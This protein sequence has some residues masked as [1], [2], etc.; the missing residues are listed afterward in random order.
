M[1][2][3]FLADSAAPAAAAATTDTTDATDAIVKTLEMSQLSIANL[4]IASLGCLAMIYAIVRF[5]IKSNAKKPP[6]EFKEYY[7]L[8]ANPMHLFA[9]GVAGILI[10]TSNVLAAIAVDPVITDIAIDTEVGEDERAKRRAVMSLNTF[11]LIFFGV[12]AALN[13]K[14]AVNIKAD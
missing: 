4:V 6:F 12:W 8:A 11:S 2:R 7:N 10:V 14:A 13:I 3:V 5:A 9:P 1:D